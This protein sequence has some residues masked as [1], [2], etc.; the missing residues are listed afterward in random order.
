MTT[1][2]TKISV[3]KKHEIYCYQ[4]AYFLLEEEELATQT[5]LKTFYDLSRD[6]VF[7]DMP[8]ILQQK[9]V[10]SVTMKNSLIIKQISIT[11]SRKGNAECGSFN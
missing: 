4:I 6:H 2:Q 8:E 10:K 3:L 11:E 7:F 9:K 1:L 5:V